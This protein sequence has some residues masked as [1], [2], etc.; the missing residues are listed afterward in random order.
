MTVTKTE[1]KEIARALKVTDFA[2]F[3]AFLSEIYTSAKAKDPNFSFAQLSES[4][5]VGSSNAHGI[6]SGKR[7]LSLKTAEKISDSLGLT[8]IQKKYFL[9]LVKKERA[10][11][12][13]DRDKAFDEVLALRQQEL[14]SELDRKQITFF[15]QWYHA[16]ILELLRLDE[17]ESTVEWVAENIRPKL[18]PTRIKESLTLLEDLGYLKFDPA[19]QRLFPAEVTITSGNEVL[20]LAVM[21]FHRQML[22]LSLDALDNIPREARDISAITV[23]ASPALREQFKNELVALRKR[24]LQLSA[25]EKSATEVVQVNLQMFPLKQAIG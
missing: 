3:R 6:I 23:T 9:N 19:R 1:I 15:S 14:P 5:G 18:V 12:S 4:I 21:S 16:A 25:E 24:F 17:A 20:S 8:G 22:R 11:S 2:N 13:T 10:R 7:S